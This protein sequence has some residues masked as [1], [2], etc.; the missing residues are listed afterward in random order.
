MKKSKI[1]TLKKEKLKEISEL[2]NISLLNLY[3]KFVAIDHYDPFETSTF[4][5]E[6]YYLGIFPEDIRSIVLERMNNYTN[7]EFI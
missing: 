5:A 3:S 1:T 2:D 4:W 6:L 7:K